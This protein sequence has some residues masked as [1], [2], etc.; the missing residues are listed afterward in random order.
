MPRFRIALPMLAA[1]G[2]ALAAC[3]SAP[4]VPEEAAEDA[5]FVLAEDLIG[6]TVGEGRFTTITGVDR[7]FTVEIDGRMEGNTVVLVEDFVY[8]DGET[9]RKTWRLTRLPDGSY[10]GTREDIVGEARGFHDGEA[11]RLEYTLEIPT[12]DGGSR[13]VGFRDVLVEL[14]DGSILNRANVGWWGFHVGEVELTIVRA[15]ET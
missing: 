12:G 1:A 15:S 3:A 14:P 5:R 9:D 13:R 2:L 8:D 6:R 10:V 4:P 11:F 7:S